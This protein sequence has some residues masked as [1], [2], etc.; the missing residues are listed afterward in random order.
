MPNRSDPCEYCGESVDENEK[1]VTVYRHRKGK[2][3]IFE[4][5]PARVCSTCGERYFSTGTVRQ[6]DRLMKAKKSGQSTVSVPIIP[7]RATG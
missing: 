7:L 4:R 1:L 5:V 2:H 6:M 3:F